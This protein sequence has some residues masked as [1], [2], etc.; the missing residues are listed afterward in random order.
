MLTLLVFTTNHGFSQKAERI[1]SLASSITNNLYLIKAQGQIVGCTSYCTNAIEDKKE[2]VGS[3]I[4]VNVEKIFALQPDLVLAM[5][6]TKP[7]DIEAL[8]RLGIKV[9]KFHT[10]KNFEEICSQ[11]IEL[12]K[13]VGRAGYASQVVEK[14]KGIVNQLKEK[15]SNYHSIQKIFF[16]IGANPIFTVIP[17]TFMDDFILYLGGVN[18]ASGLKHGSITREA[19]VL[20]NPDAIIIASMGGF[21]QQEKETWGSFNEINA[22]KN[23]KVFVVDAELACSPT[24]TNFRKSLEILF[25]YLFG[26]E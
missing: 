9:I 16:Q 20:Q 21:E 19:V 18:I 8:E 11:L 7:Q 6:L 4:N 2:I 12:G 15:A 25:V 13:L 22:V 23:N 14:E 24:P 10:P 17:N 1:V 3:A 5:Q 26:G